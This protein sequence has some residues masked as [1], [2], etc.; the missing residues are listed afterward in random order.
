MLRLLLLLL[1]VWVAV[2]V[3]GVIVEGLFWLAVVGLVFFV[4]TAV[5]GASRRR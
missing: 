3:V 4:A 1:L 5:L 2:T